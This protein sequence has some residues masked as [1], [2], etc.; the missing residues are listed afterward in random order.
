MST[1]PHVSHHPSSRRGP[2]G[3]PT[4]LWATV[5][6][7]LGIL[8]AVLGLV[9]VLMWADAHN[10]RGAADRAATIRMPDRR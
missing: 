6:M 2:I 9:A 7:L 5:S 1:V 3:F 10:A 8:V 4:A